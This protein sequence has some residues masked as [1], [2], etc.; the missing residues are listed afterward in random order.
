M[1][2]FRKAGL[3]PLTSFFV[4]LLVGI[5]NAKNKRFDQIMNSFSFDIDPCISAANLIFGRFLWI[6]NVRKRLHRLP[7]ITACFPCR[8]SVHFWAGRPELAAAKTQP[9]RRHSVLL[10]YASMPNKFKYWDVLVGYEGTACSLSDSLSVVTKLVLARCQHIII[11]S[12]NVNPCFWTDNLPPQ[13]KLSF[14]M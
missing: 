14:T 5:K 8:S 9:L 6:R 2:E 12:K 1:V 7:L 4:S 3:L 10:H 11:A 13:L